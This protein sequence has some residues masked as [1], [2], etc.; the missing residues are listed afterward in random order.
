MGRFSYL[1]IDFNSYFASVEQ[2]MNPALRGKPIAVV[3][4]MSDTTSAIAASYEAKAFGVKTGTRIWEAKRMCPG[5][6]L[7]PARHELYV[8]IHEQLKEEV[9]NHVPL[10]STGSIDEF[11]CKLIGDECEP[12]NARKIA[13]NMKAGIKKNVGACLNSSIGIAPTRLLSKIASDMQKP[14]GLTLLEQKDLPRIL[15]PLQLTDLPGIASNMEARL[16][17]AGIT[18]IEQLLSLEPKAARHVWGSVGGE[19]YW[20]ELHGIDVPKSD[21]GRRS[22]GH[23][24]VLAPKMR[25]K[26]DARFVARSLLLKCAT[27][28]RRLEVVAGGFGLAV[29]PDYGS[30]NREPIVHESKISPTQDSFTLLQYLD[31]F[32]SELPK[33]SGPFRKVSI[34]LYHLSDE[35]KRARDLFVETRPDG[36][37]KKEILWRSVDKLVARYGRETVTLASQKDLGL[38][39]LGA[40]IAFTRVPDA[41]EFRE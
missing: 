33:K 16:H 26:D 20:Y 35:S 13:L 28:I 34:W 30:T 32:W 31:Q 1:T 29:H 37:T 38:Q 17:R 11:T 21:E 23:S 40:K 27:R 3:P 36:F 25:G 10:L 22:V 6:I 4:V 2:Q 5:L 12:A 14:N 9:Q 41:Q 18:S 24:R 39:Y 15:F 19:R 7:V 8:D